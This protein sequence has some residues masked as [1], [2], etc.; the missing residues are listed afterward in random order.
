MSEALLRRARPAVLIAATLA[1]LAA[2]PASHRRPRRALADPDTMQDHRLLPAPGPAFP[3]AP[4]KRALLRW[5]AECR[6]AGARH[7]PVFRKPGTVV[8]AWVADREGDLMQLEFPVDSFRG[9]EVEPGVT[10]ADCVVRR[11]R[12][13]K[14]RWSRE[15]T[16]PLRLHAVEEPT[17]APAPTPESQP[18]GTASQPAAPT[19]EAR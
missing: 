17:S 16:A 18:T 8:I 1:G 19:G 14:V 2:C 11:A 6:A 15:G 9:W 12:A 7:D 3:A 10:L 5:A 13:G 4:G